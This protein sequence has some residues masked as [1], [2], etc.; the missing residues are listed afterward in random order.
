[1]KNDDSNKDN[2]KNNRRKRSTVHYP[3]KCQ[4]CP[5]IETSHVICFAH[6]LTGFNMRA[7]LSFNGLTLVKFAKN[8]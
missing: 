8:L 4:C 5:H 2:N 3:I 6:Q 1:M 7:T